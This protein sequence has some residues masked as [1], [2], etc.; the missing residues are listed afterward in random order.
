MVYLKFLSQAE[1]GT[2]L[3]YLHNKEGN[4]LFKVLVTGGGW[5]VVWDIYT[6][7]REMVYLKFLSQAEGGV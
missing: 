2:S 7:R 5:S 4:G 1:G 3:G 6:T